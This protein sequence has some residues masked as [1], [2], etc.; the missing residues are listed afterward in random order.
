M[1]IYAEVKIFSTS[2]NEG[3]CSVCS[4]RTELALEL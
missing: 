4:S 1:T 3:L 2:E